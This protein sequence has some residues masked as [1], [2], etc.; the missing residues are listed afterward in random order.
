MMRRCP[1]AG[2]RRGGKWPTGRSDCP[3][4][5]GGGRPGPGARP[6]PRRLA[7]LERAGAEIAAVDLLDGAKLRRGLPGHRPDRFDRQQQHGCGP[8]Q[9]GPRRPHRT[10]EPVRRGEECAR[11]P[12]RLRLVSRPERGR[13]RRYLPA[14]VVH[15]GRDTAKRRPLRDVAADRVHGRV[16]QRRDRRPS[17]EERRGTHLRRRVGRR[18]L[19]RRGRCG[20]VRRPDPR[21][22]RHRQRSRRGRRT[23]G[24]V[25]QRSRHARRA[26]VRGIRPPPTR[27]GADA[28][29]PPD[30]HPAIQR[31]RRAAHV[32]RS[33]RRDAVQTVSELEAVGR[34]VRRVAADD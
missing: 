3:P 7:D 5:D 17:P 1:R 2:P 31:G 24:R 14:Q 28:Q 25:V 19:H 11:A 30:H 26:E 15:R 4:V 33:L 29:V 12:A 21:P 8:D 34:S 9:S 23:V 6:P 20:D 18:Q 22:R 32:A 13:G 27:S 10:P 16:D